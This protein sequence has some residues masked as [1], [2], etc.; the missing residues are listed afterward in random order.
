MRGWRTERRV[1]SRDSIVAVFDDTAGL[2]GMEE[3]NFD[4]TWTAFGYSC[5]VGNKGDLEALG[6]KNH[7]QIHLTLTS[8]NKRRN[9]VS[10]E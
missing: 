9:A 2:H 4:E 5:R 3:T 10:S 8:C 6:I 7:M 1:C